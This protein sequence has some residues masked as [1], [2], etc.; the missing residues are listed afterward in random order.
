MPANEHEDFSIS[1]PEDHRTR[2]WLKNNNPPGD[3]FA[4]PRCGARTRRQTSCLG[5]AMR[6]GRCRMHGG[7]STG[8]K[9][10]EGAS[11]AGERI[12]N[13]VSVRLRRDFS[14]AWRGWF[15]ATVGRSWRS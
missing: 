13:M 2:G 6:N 12:G 8:P 10:A 9:T 3:F 1:G 14:A 4:A 15:C 5:P 11:A 7:M